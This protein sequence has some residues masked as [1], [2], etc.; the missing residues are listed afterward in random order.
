MNRIEPL[1]Y[2]TIAAWLI[3]PLTAAQNDCGDAVIVSSG[4]TLNAIAKRCD[5][6]V[7]AILDAN[8]LLHDRNNIATGTILTM[9][10]AS[11]NQSGTEQSSAQDVT[12]I[13]TPEAI[14]ELV[15]PVALYPDVLLSEI[16]PASTYPL[17]IV[18]A[19]RWRKTHDDVEAADEMDWA[20][21][22]KAL[23]RYPDALNMLNDDLQWTVRLGDAFLAQPDDV[24]DGIQRMRTK[25]EAAGNLQTTEQQM[26]VREKTEVVEVIRIEPANPRYVYVPIYDPYAV[27]YPYHGARVVHGPL[28]TFSTRFALGGWMNYGLNWHHRH[29]YH[30][31]YVPTYYGG[32]SRRTIT[33]RNSGYPIATRTSAHVEGSGQRW[34][35]DSNRSRRHHGRAVVRNS[36]SSSNRNHITERGDTRQRRA[37]TNAHAARINRLDNTRN[38]RDTRQT[39]NRSRTQENLHRRQTEAARAQPGN[40]VRANNSRVSTRNENLRERRDHNPQH[41]NPQ[42]RNQQQRNAIRARNAETVRA[43]TS[44]ANN[45]APRRVVQPSAQQPR[46]NVQRRAV[47][48][49]ASA[50]QHAQPRAVQR[51]QV[52]APPRNAV[53]RQQAPAVNH[54]RN[55]SNQRSQQSSVS[56]SSSDHGNR[57]AGSRERA[58]NDSRG[59]SRGRINE[60]R[61]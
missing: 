57:N 37:V 14:D 9:P 4:D 5:T 41:R 60:Q 6:S 13:L 19:A 24:F 30:H 36:G 25:A 39:I 33:R 38:G 15:A 34:R 28:I 48:R 29:I 12:D 45:Q 1:I 31:H 27:Y 11:A 21:S 55:T 54:N 61:H 35:H 3:V 46:A 40:S 59:G 26:I 49:R 18:Q 51:P 17:E 7:S 53:Q 10:D 50:Q 47:Q 23:T 2:G 58:R 43:A 52:S 8:K 44:R 32:H 56:R 42:H 20:P 22:I 16:L